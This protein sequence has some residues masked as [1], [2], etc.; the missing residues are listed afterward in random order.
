MLLNRSPCAE[1]AAPS[2]RRSPLR[3]VAHG[4]EEAV[5]EEGV[6]LEG[7]DVSDK[8]QLNGSATA[9]AVLLIH[10]GQQPAR[11]RPLASGRVHSR[12]NDGYA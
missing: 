4:P 12:E 2:S 9:V 3:P 5:T 1:T 8:N 10:V 6:G 7:F 11:G